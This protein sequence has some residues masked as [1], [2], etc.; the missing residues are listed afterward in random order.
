[1]KSAG[2]PAA[3]AARI[4]ISLTPRIGPDLG[5]TASSTSFSSSSCCSSCC[6]NGGL[7]TTKQPQP[8]LLSISCS[9]SAR[10]DPQLLISTQTG[11]CLRHRPAIS[12]SGPHPPW[13]APPRL[14][15]PGGPPWELPVGGH[16]PGAPNCF[17]ANK[18]SMLL[19]GGN[20][21]ARNL[22]PTEAGRP[23]RSSRSPADTKKR[24]KRA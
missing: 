22:S 11:Y 7:R 24:T 5:F 14:P 6:C 20:S 21:S 8:Y 13:G 17:R 1:M 9:G 19:L 16:P 18:K 12:F 10:G 2:S 3:K 15:L 4:S 23:S